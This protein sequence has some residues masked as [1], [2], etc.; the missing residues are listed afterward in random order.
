MMVWHVGA[1]LPCDNIREAAPRCVWIV[2]ARQS[3]PVVF[4]NVGAVPRTVS[5]SVCARQSLAVMVWGTRFEISVRIQHYNS[6][7]QITPQLQKRYF[8]HL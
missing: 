4:R 3:I 5:V 7:K 8:V 2:C 1:E 6:S